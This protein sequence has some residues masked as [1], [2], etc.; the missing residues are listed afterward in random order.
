MLQS[1]LKAERFEPVVLKGIVKPLL[2]AHGFEGRSSRQKSELPGTKPRA[3]TSTICQFPESTTA[4]TPV[5]EATSRPAAS[6]MTTSMSVAVPHWT[7][8]T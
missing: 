7:A 5:M 4:V 3:E 8:A 1:L 6:R 2:P